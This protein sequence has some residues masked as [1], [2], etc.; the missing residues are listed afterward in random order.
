M[1]RQSA[2]LAGG[3]VVHIVFGAVISLFLRSAPPDAPMQMSPRLAW[4]P[5]Q[6]M[7]GR[8]NG[9]GQGGDRRAPSPAAERPVVAPHQP[10]F[11]LPRIPDAVATIV[12]PGVEVAF[13]APHASGPGT[14]D[15]GVGKGEGSDGPGVGTRPGT[16]AGE[17]D[18][19]FVDGAPGVTSPRPLVEQKPE[20]TVNAISARVQGAVLLEATVLPD[21]SVA[22]VRVLKAMEPSHGLDGK[23]AEA[24][25]A[26]K[27]LP[28]T[29]QG[30][31]VAVKVLVELYFTLR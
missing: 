14:H 18:R 7:P 15:R 1:G 31:P 6:T 10:R 29:Y 5:V 4:T 11:L 2:R 16:G 28:G 12:L 25:R 27:F 23:A 8:P 21:G 13:T 26:W 9:G 24:L 17:G 3:T 30:R 19:P 20:Y 22:D